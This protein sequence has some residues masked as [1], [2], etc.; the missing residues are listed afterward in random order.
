MNQECLFLR[1]E[2]RL[3]GICFSY[4]SLDVE[5]SFASRLSA[6]NVN[7][8]CSDETQLLQISS[9]QAEL[10]LCRKRCRRFEVNQEE[11]LTTLEHHVSQ[12][13]V[14]ATNMAELRLDLAQLRLQ[15]T[16]L[17]EEHSGLQDRFEDVNHSQLDELDRLRLQN[18]RLLCDLKEK[19]EKISAM[20]KEMRDAERSAKG[21]V[22]ELL[23]SL[24]IMEAQMGDLLKGAGSSVDSSES[25]QSDR[26]QGRALAARVSFLEQTSKRKEEEIQRLQDELLRKEDQLDQLEQRVTDS[27]QELDNAVKKVTHMESVVQR[28]QS[29]KDS[30]QEENRLLRAR[31]VALTQHPSPSTAHVAE[32]GALNQRP[33][34]TGSAATVNMR[35]TRDNTAVVV[36][37]ALPSVS[38]GRRSTPTA[39]TSGL[40]QARKRPRS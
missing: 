13:E 20:E 11:L 5:G 22:N 6:A 36:P 23:E 7:D 1:R 37:T 40:T 4:N 29:A 19:S 18:D 8:E 21:R 27:T 32:L 17:Q 28:L 12:A 31:E 16:Q 9:L 10:L 25:Q 39:R 38:V 34:R 2:L 14:S 24:C 15:F 26:V 30:L 3:H 35:T 33:P